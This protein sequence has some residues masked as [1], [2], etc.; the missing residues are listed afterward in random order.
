MIVYNPKPK[1]CMGCIKE[2]E[3]MECFFVNYSKE[4]ECP[5]AECI[6]KI[7]CIIDCNVRHQKKLDVRYGLKGN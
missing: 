4:H 1:V 3:N 6:V 5:C 2:R 7:T